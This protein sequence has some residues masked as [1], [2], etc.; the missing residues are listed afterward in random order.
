MDTIKKAYKFLKGCEY[1]AVTSINDKFP[2]VRPFGAIMEH[3]THFYISTSPAKEVYRQLK[4][5]EHIQIF[6][7]KSGTREWIRI[8]GWAKECADFEIKKL[9][10][11]EYPALRKHFVSEKSKNFILFQIEPLRI[12]FKQGEKILMERKT[13]NKLVRDKIPEMLDKNRGE[14][15]TEI[16]NNEK[17]IECL[18]AK[19]KEE[20][21]EV[22]TA[23]SKENLAEELA[24]LLEVMGAIAKTNN[25]DFAEVE[26]IKTIKKEKR[27]GFDCKIFLKSSNV[28]K[29]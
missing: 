22:I 17:Y 11:G 28:V 14:T 2:A 15:E 19:L 3:E 26:K 21:E 1:F 16:L 29:I 8:T 6:A 4:A 20:C 13:F 5:N 23:D 9:M 27:G 18:Y 25:I 12:E 7:L 24:D 10:L